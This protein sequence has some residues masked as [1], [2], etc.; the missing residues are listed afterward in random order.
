MT[1]RNWLIILTVV[2]ASTALLR[3]AGV[4]DDFWMDEIWSYDLARTVQR[5]SDVLLEPRFQID[6]NHPLNTLL[7]WAMGEQRHWWIYRV[8]SLLAGLGAVVVA[9]MIAARRG[10]AA[11]ILAAVLV[12]CSYPLV[13]FSSEARGYAVVVLFALMAVDAAERYLAR[14]T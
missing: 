8:P 14:P 11:A 5:P 6:N 13:F 7:I 3:A 10:R 12:G 4:F 9:T 1:R 2:I